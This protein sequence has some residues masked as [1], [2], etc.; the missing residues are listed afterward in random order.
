M[1]NDGTFAE[2]YIV[3]WKSVLGHGAGNPSIPSFSVPSGKTQYQHGID[4]GV[5]A[6]NA[7]KARERRK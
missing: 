6:A 1:S 4:M 3:G 7:E 5:K 2:G